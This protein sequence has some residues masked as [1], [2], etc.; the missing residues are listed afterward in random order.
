MAKEKARKLSDDEIDQVSG[1]NWREND[2]LVALYNRYNPDD[3]L[4]GYDPKIE[5]WVCQVWD[6]P[7]N[8]EWRPII[9]DDNGY[10][11][12]AYVLPGMGFVNHET[13]MR[14]TEERA[15]NK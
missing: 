2:A 6:A 8:A 5:R 15:K 13:F 4:T 11:F 12:N 3:Q 14:L 1:G 9:L 7:T 10:H